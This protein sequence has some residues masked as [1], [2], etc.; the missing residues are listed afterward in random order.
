MNSKKHPLTI[1]WSFV[2]AGCLCLSAAA[3]AEGTTG[4]GT[5]G[6][7]APITVTRDYGVT[8]RANGRTLPAE[9]SAFLRSDGVLYV[10]VRAAAE[11]LGMKVE[12]NAKKRLAEIKTANG[13]TFAFPLGREYFWFNGQRYDLPYGTEIEQHGAGPGFSVMVPASAVGRLFGA[14]VQWDAQAKALDIAKTNGNVPAD[15]KSGFQ[16][17]WDVWSPEP[18]D[19]LTLAKDLFPRVTLS[20]GKL[21]VRVPDTRAYASTY[22]YYEGQKEAATLAPGKTYTYAAGRKNAGIYAHRVDASGSIEEEYWIWL[23]AGSPNLAYSIYGNQGVSVLIQDRHGKVVSLPRMQQVVKEANKLHSCG[24]VDFRGQDGSAAALPL[25]CVAAQYGADEPGTSPQVEPKSKLPAVDYAIPRGLQDQLAAYWMNL[26]GSGGEIG[27]LFVAPRGWEPANAD[28][29]ADGSAGI[30]LQNPRDPD[31]YVSLSTIPA[32]Q[33]CAISAIG[34]YFPDLRQW[35]E[36]QAFPGTDMAFVDRRMLDAHTV[37][38]SKQAAAGSGYA[39]KGIAYERHGDGGGA[40]GAGEAQLDATR[41][42]LAET[43]LHFLARQLPG[44][45]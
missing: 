34:T 4:A 7:E 44:L 24:T 41:P 8:V 3:S 37:A 17:E 33:G 6:A 11:A 35:A 32:C 20:G 30:R 16:R 10:S 22:L 27:L 5:A 39:V 2:L 43:I 40:F 36:D 9:H 42:D 29:G 12:W 23:D 1:V 25:N 14:E 28:V 45:V 26:D 19:E 13:Q 18:H 15:I 21:S 38:Y 31:Q